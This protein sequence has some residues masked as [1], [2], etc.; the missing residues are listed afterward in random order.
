MIQRHN[1]TASED[2]RIIREYATCADPE[3]LAGEIGVT[4]NALAQRARNFSIKREKRKPVLWTPEMDKVIIQKYPDTKAAELAKEMGLKKSSICSRAHILGLKHTKEFKS[5]SGLEGRQMQG[6]NK[7]KGVKGWSVPGSEK[8]R[9]KKGQTPQNALHDKAVTVRFHKKQS[10]AYKYIRLGPMKWVPLHT[11]LWEQKNGKLP[12]GYCLWF[13]DRD[14][15]NCS[16]QNLE[17][18]HRSENLRRNRDAHYS[19]LASKKQKQKSTGVKITSRIIKRTKVEVN[20]EL[21][22]L[23]KPVLKKAAKLLRKIKKENKKIRVDTPDQL[24][25]WL[26]RKKV[27]TTKPVQTRDAIKGKIKV[28]IKPGLIVFINPGDDVEKVRAKY[29]NKPLLEKE[30]RKNYQKSFI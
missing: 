29:L 22:S 24:D 13:I 7:M 28:Q 16:L 5:K 25:K 12:E 23:K 9:F 8:T 14:T 27:D 2:A 10:Q 11:Y 30:E 19:L 4:L 20:K 1:Y 26:N 17:L 21:E 15:M 6:D 3:K 18:I